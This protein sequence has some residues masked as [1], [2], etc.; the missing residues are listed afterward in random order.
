MQ[1]VAQADSVRQ[2]VM[3]TFAELRGETPDPS[4]LLEMVLISESRYRGRSYRTHDLMAM[5]LADL[6]V[7]QIYNDAGDML[8][9]IDLNPRR[10][11]RQAA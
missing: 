8:R 7:V 10:A 9:M 1:V 2:L 11:V 4:G 5:W 6:R 3:S